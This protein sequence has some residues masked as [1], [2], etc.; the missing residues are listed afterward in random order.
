[1]QLELAEYKDVLE[2]KAE[3]QLTA[4]PLRIDLLIIKKS[5]DVQLN[6]NIARIF[7]SINVVEYKSPRDYL[8]VKDFFKVYAYANLYAA[9]GER[10][11]FSDLTITFITTRHPRTLINYLVHKRHYTLEKVR[12]ESRW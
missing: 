12:R 11:D 9:I 4:E 7:R 3:Y 5:G 6:K 1:M 8:S 10:I 2:F